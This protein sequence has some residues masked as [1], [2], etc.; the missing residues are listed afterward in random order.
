M[1]RLPASTVRNFA[2]PA[3]SP[4][5]SFHGSQRED[6]IIASYLAP[7]GWMREASSAA[8]AVFLPGVKAVDEGNGRGRG[9]TGVDGFR[10]NPDRGCGGDFI[11]MKAPEVRKDGKYTTTV[12]LIKAPRDTVVA[13]IAAINRNARARK[14][15]PLVVVHTDGGTFAPAISEW[16]IRDMGRMFANIA[17]AE[18]WPCWNGVPIKPENDR[19]RGAAGSPASVWVTFLRRELLGYDAKGN[20]KV[21]Y[22][23]DANGTYATLTASFSQRSGAVF[24][25]GTPAQFAAEVDAATVLR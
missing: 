7:F 18:A 20:P 22:T 3:P 4:L 13:F 14:A 23:P 17:N 21:R 1:A 24:R 8:K 25:T 15:F 10:V 6:A 12:E 11:S 16:C 19:A 2:V 9:A 5:P